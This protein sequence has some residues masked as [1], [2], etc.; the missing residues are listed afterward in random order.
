VKRPQLLGDSGRRSQ[1]SPTSAPF[2]GEIDTPNLDRPGLRGDPVSPIFHFG[3]GLLTDQ[4]DAAYR[5]RPPPRRH[6][7]DARRSYRTGFKG[8]APAMRAIS[9]TGSW[10]CPELLR[11]AGYMTADGGQMAYSG[12]TIE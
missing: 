1:G 7:H 9:T 10:H 3:A 11:D 12:N 5:N 2:G 4:V 6:R 8:R